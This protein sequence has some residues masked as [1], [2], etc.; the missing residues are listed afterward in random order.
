MF[1][2]HKNTAL[3]ILR[4]FEFSGVQFG[5]VIQYV[6]E[7]YMCVPERLYV[8]FLCECMNRVEKESI[9]GRINS[10]ILLKI[11]PFYLAVE[12]LFS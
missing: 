3:N 9:P 12:I 5:I 6:V 10:T 2:I 1:H 11:L 8:W 7:V 4:Y